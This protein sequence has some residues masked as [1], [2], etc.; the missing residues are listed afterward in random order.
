[1]GA[2]SSKNIAK[3]VANIVSNITNNIINK[4]NV[5]NSNSQIITINDTHGN[6]TITN[7]T[8]NISA[9][10]NMQSLLEAIS[11]QDVRQDL[12]QQIGQVSKALSKDINLANI[13]ISQN[14]IDDAISDAINI[15][16][17]VSQ[18]CNSSI[19]N[20]QQ[21]TVNVSDG[22]VTISNNSFMIISSVITSCV[23]NSLS[24]SSAI[25]NL[26]QKLDQTSSASV[27]GISIG[28]IASILLICGLL[29][30]IFPMVLPLLAAK[31]YPWIFGLIIIIAG[32][33]FLICWNFWTTKQFSTTLWALPF[34]DNCLPTNIVSSSNKYQNYD[35]AS[36]KA[37]TIKNCIGYFFKANE[38]YGNGWR[39]VN[40]PM[41][42]FYDKL[43]SKCKTKQDDSPIF[44]ERVC[45]VGNKE[46]SQTN[47]QNNKKPTE[48]DFFINKSNATF[49]ILKKEN[50][51]SVAKKFQDS[52]NSLDSIN[53]PNIIIENNTREYKNSNYS[54]S[55]ETNL[56]KFVL[57]DGSNSFSVDGPGLK[58]SKDTPPNA[59]GILIKQKRSWLLY[60]G[61]ALI[62]VGFIALLYP[63]LKKNEKTKEKNDTKQN[64]ETPIKK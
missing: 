61:G 46:A 22:D 53:I 13:S 23:E 44:V 17:N 59:C 26:Q 6:V 45:F 57:T 4:Q 37:L 7:N 60:T 62:F 33:V 39:S 31:K 21:V 15:C 25:S 50:L 10:V 20:Q 38:K 32:V 41:T 43:D 3:S 12:E 24:K 36:K 52:I 56:Y 47:F 2:S 35:L 14:E 28:G 51:W 64:K 34:E 18:T 8:F 11:D 54:L 49:Q 27:S 40:P 29:F 30:I 19:S 58:I 48:G 1:M 63:L 16:I 55:S 5:S 9:S 42:Y